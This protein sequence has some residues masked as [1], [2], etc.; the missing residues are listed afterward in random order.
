M[1]AAL[2]RFEERTGVMCDE[3]D[4]IGRR[5]LCSEEHCAVERVES[6]R[7]EFLGVAQVVKPSRHSDARWDRAVG[8]QLIRQ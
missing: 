2:V 6:G 4:H 8:T 7:R 3:A 1:Q 5:A